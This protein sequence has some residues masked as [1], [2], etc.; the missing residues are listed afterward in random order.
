MPFTTVVL[1][2]KILFL[3]WTVTVHTKKILSC[4]VLIRNIILPISNSTKC[5]TVSYYTAPSSLISQLLQSESDWGLIK[6]R[7]FCD[8]EV[9]QMGP[10][11][12]PPNKVAGR[13]FHGTKGQSDSCCNIEMHIRY[14]LR[15][16]S[17]TCVRCF[18]L[19][20]CMLVC[21]NC[22]SQHLIIVF[23]NV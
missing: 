23:K 13:L 19:V 12:R 21:V 7:A 2:N 1:P 11:C 3:L 18:L 20:V 5:Q 17:T 14:K 15:C 9:T 10:T 16:P 8:M 22:P 6:G 4:N